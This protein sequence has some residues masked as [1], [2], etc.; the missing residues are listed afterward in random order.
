MDSARTEDELAAERMGS[1]ERQLHKF[2]PQ[3]VQRNII[4]PYCGHM[5]FQRTRRMCCDLLRKAVVA[6]L[7]ADRMLDTAEAAERASNN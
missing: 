2:V 6:V 3:G 5:N 1:V 4:C 7:L